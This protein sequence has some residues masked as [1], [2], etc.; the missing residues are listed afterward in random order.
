MPQHALRLRASR[1]DD[2]QHELY[3]LRDD[4]EE[5]VNLYATRAPQAK[6]LFKKLGQ[7][8]QAHR[9]AGDQGTLGP[10]SPE[11]L[12]ILKNLGYADDG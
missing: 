6:A 2:G 9:R 12:E 8:V 7:L 11:E 10:L 4:P 1:D 5:L 3:D